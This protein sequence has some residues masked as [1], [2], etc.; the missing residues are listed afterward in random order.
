MRLADGTLWPIPVTLDVPEEI[1]AAAGSAGTLALRDS[2]AMIL[3]VLRV[4]ESWEPDVH[5]E[6]VAVFST[7]DPSHPGVAYLLRHTHRR[8][9]TGVLEVL[10][11]PE[12]RDFQSLRH[13]P[14][15]LRAEFARRDWNRVVAFQTRNPMHRAHQQLTLRA[16]LEHDA[17][18]LIHPVV[19]VTKPGD[20][21]PQTRVP[22]YQALLPTYPK[23][24]VMLS[25]LPLAMRMAGPREA[26]WHAI[27]RGNYG[28]THFIIGRDH[29]GPG[30]TADGTPFYGP[31]D[32]HELVH[33]HAPELGVHPVRFKQLVYVEG[34][35][36]YIP[37]DEVPRGAR[38]LSISGTL[39]RR[40]LAE[41]RELPEWFSPP[42]VAAALR[43]HYVTLSALRS[44]PGCCYWPVTSGEMQALLNVPR[45][46]DH[47]DHQRHLRQPEPARQTR[48]PPG[49]QVPQPGEPAPPGPHRL[50]PLIPPPVTHR[51]PRETH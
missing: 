35:G 39:L 7:T 50:H 10:Q 31:Y 3:A 14:T 25:L 17:N 47:R 22:C 16:A 13:T 37:E 30:A 23:G 28:A 26:L 1:A 19:G 36:A 2:N 11:L 8:Y 38:V 44:W 27:I 40:W 42:E 12:H 21:D 9:I 15:Q 33:R 49:L 34:A 41:G 29:S 4:T 32:A 5:A 24:R 48:S 6:A 51:N 20:I 45:R 43:R 18:L 46:G